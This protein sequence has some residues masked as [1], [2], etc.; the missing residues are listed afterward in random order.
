[1]DVVLTKHAWV[2]C[3]Q[4]HFDPHQVKILLEKV[5]YFTGEMLWKICPN[6][7]AVISNVEGKCVVVTVHDESRL[8]KHAYNRSRSKRKLRV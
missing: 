8:N 7:V 5:P 1:M 6:M 2:R 4:R 3:R